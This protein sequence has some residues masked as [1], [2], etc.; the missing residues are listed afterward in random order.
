MVSF[1]VAFASFVVDLF[2]DA[3]PR[4]FAT[5]SNGRCVADN[6][7][8]CSGVGTR[9]SSRSSDSAMWAPRLVDT[10]AWISSMITVST[11]RRRSCA[12]DVSSRNNDSGVV[13]RM[14]AGVRW[15]LARSAAGVSPVRT[16]IDGTWKGMSPANA[17]LEIP[18]SGARRLR[19]TSTAS[20][21]NGEM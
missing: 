6:P 13:I 17:A 19:S 11:D 18:A 4:N 14:S 16:A 3:P 12:F 1:L 9:R 10:S 20:A 7:M 8:R 21:F 5:S 2:V 15:N